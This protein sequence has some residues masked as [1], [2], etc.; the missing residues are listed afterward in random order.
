MELKACILE[1]LSE[2]REQIYPL[3]FPASWKIA[4]DKDKS[5][6]P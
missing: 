6:L 5:T 3:I 1:G 2:T 4:Q